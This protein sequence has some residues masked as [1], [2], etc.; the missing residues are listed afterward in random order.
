MA[1]STGVLQCYT[2]GENVWNRQ[3]Q[4]MPNGRLVSGNSSNAAQGPLLLQYPGRRRQYLL[5][6]VDAAL[7]FAGGLRYSVVDMAQNN[8]LGAVLLPSSVLV[9]TPMPRYVTTEALTAVRHANGTD[10]WVVVHGWQNNE[11]LSYRVLPTGLD[12]VPVRSQVG[13]YHGPPG[14]A[15]TSYGRV[16]LRASP[17]GRRLAAGVPNRGVEVFDFDNINGQVRNPRPINFPMLTGFDGYGLEF[18]A[19]SN[20]LYVA[21]IISLYQVAMGSALTPIQ[22]GASKFSLLQ[23]GPDNRIYVANYQARALGV[24]AAPDVVGP[25]CGFLP[26]GQDLNGRLSLSGLPNFPNQPPRPTRIVAPRT[27]CVG[28]LVMLSAEGLLVSGTGQQWDFGDPASGAANY[29]VGNP[30]THRY[31]QPGSYPVALT[32]NTVIGP[33]RRTQLITVSAVPVLRLLPRDTLICEFGDVLLQASSQPAGTTF[34]WQDGSTEPFF[35]TQAAGR[36]TLE[37]R[38]AGGCLARDSVLVSTR[39][40]FLPNIITPNGDSQN[41]TFVLKGLNA[42]DWSLRI[43][44]SWGREIY[45]QA[46]YDNDWAAPGQADGVYFYQLRHRTTGQVLKGWLDVRR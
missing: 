38:N 19:N 30:V 12:T 27:S 29:A 43:Y 15:V 7:T 11:F 16:S 35:R 36:Y 14:P 39:A 41:Q 22:L 31:A 25:G 24:V 6:T 2:D 20:V 32:L 28:Q 8:G 34:R 45:Q 1:D 40:C 44:N 17:D 26:G 21:D 4:A 23:R 3:G 37:V 33:L 10:Y 18:S 13:S 42:P 9:P 46:S 5:F